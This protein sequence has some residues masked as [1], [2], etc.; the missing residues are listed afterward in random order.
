V[1][2]TTGVVLGSLSAFQE[3]ILTNRFWAESAKSPP[4]KG[5]S[6]GGCAGE[7][8]I[9][10]IYVWAIGLLLANGL[11]WVSTAFTVPGNWLIVG[12]TA[13]YAYLLPPELEPRVSWIVVGVALALAVFGELIEFVA[14]A[15]GAAK[16]GGSRRGIVMAIAG[17][18]IGSLV[19]AAVLSPIPLIGPIIGALGGGAF[20]GAY[21]GEEGTGRTQDERIAIGKG[22]MM[23]R[24]LGTAGKLIIGIVMLVIITLD[25]FYDFA[26]SP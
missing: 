12:F 23:G 6:P 9:G 20:A 22:A 26:E 21:Y 4:A 10:M 5:A 11:A 8:G 19:G 7:R 3:A 15:A 24:L 16:Q 2:Q 18:F 1:D 25:L 17:A 13:V 14:G